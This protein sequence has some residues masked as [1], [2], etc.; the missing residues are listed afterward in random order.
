MCEV[1][2]ASY[3]NILNVYNK[4]CNL[5]NP[6]FEHTNDVTSFEPESPGSWSSIIFCV[7]EHLSQIIFPTSHSRLNSDGGSFQVRGRQS[8]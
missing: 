2:S 7:L 6:G 5:C 4:V 1:S 8:S 3:S